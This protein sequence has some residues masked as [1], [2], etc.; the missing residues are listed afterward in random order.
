MR[1]FGIFCFM[2]LP[3]VGGEVRPSGK[4]SMLLVATYTRKKEIPSPLPAKICSLW[5][6][7]AGWWWGFWL[8]WQM[9]TL[10]EYVRRYGC[11][12]STQLPDERKRIFSGRIYE[13]CKNNSPLTRGRSECGW[14]MRYVTATVGKKIMLTIKNISNILLF[15][16]LTAFTANLEKSRKYK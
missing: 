3:R 10:C 7:Y 12:R 15:T 16:A 1:Y 9:A 13:V 14:R 11:F 8:S 6:I 2:I 5:L 4:K